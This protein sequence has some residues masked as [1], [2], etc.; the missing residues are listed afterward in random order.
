MKSNAP[1]SIVLTEILVIVIMAVLFLFDV[2]LWPISGW[3]LELRRI[4]SGTIRLTLVIVFYAVSVFAWPLLYKLFRL[5]RNLKRGN[6]FVVQN[7]GI[8]RVVS[9]CC[10]AI[11][12][13]CFAGGFFYHPL[14]F[15]A[16]AA[17]FMT[18]IVRVVKNVF[19]QAIEMKDELDF[20][21]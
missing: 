19:H 4:S 13:V 16:A 12:I 9:Y 21:V 17:L 15:I 2:F 5:L 1:R 10:L 18:P 14:F 8:L 20:T 11:G 6:V 3:Y 7:V